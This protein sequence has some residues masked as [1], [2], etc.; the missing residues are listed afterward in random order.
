MLQKGDKVVV[1]PNENTLNMLGK[2]YEV[3]HVADFKGDVWVMLKGRH[4]YIS[5]CYLQKVEDILEQLKE[6]NFQSKH[7]DCM[8]CAHSMIDDDDKLVCVRYEEHF[9]VSNHALCKNWN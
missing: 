2:I 5:E 6:D 4:V 8:N 3:D 1:V 9:K 7:Y